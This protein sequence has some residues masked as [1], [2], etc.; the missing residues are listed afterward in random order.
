MLADIQARGEEAA[1]EWAK[2][3]DGEHDED[4]GDVE[5]SSSG[6]SGTALLTKEELEE[7][8]KDVPCKVNFT[9]HM[10]LAHTFI[11]FQPFAK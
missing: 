3:L 6:F 11:C 1:L 2:K 8:T 7:Q 4:S 10:I 5:H 9:I